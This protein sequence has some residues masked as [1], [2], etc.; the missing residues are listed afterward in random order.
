[1]EGVLE[2]MLN[3]LKELSLQKRL[4][5][6]FSYERFLYAQLLESSSKFIGIYGSRGV[7]KTTVMLQ[8]AEALEYKADELLYISCD[9]PVL[10]DVSL[11]ELVNAFYKYGGKCILIDEVHEAKDFEQELKSVYDF[12]DIKLI[13]S[14]SSAIKISNP[15][16][17]RRYSMFHLPVLSFKEYIELSTSVVLENY[18]MQELLNNHEVIAAEVL[19]SLK[20]E[21][22]LK[23]FRQYLD[24]GA[25][26]F[27]FENREGYRQR[28]LDTVNTILHT[29]IVVIHN[30]SGEKINTLKKLLASICLSNP[31]E[32]SV[33]AL[34]KK[35][36]VS[37]VTL[38]KYIEY[39]HKA[40]LLRHVTHEA[41]R[42][43]SMQRPDK[44]YLSNSTLFTS[45]CLTPKVGTIRESFFASAVS[46]GNDL[47]YVDKGDFLVDEKYTFEIGGK[48]KSF[49]QI[50]DLPDSY[51]ASD[52][53]E[54]GF[55]NRIPL[56]LF[57]FLY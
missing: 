27:Y 56:W 25:Y 52:E 49:E 17:A 51:V 13:F 28:V 7:G 54:I 5:T 3:Q 16:F 19:L 43:K 31:L 53:I 12:I 1:M 10:A 32:L 14:G 21:K 34:S 42:F 46:Y 9:H 39:M 57:G 47:H 15:S 8:V 38:Y 22:I 41:K 48:N 55:K 36:G 35:V 20:D 50:K 44:L 33:D 40:E 11:F 18:S 24:H 45:L 2:R 23:L 29:D 26:P 4:M 37:K 30:I 6:R